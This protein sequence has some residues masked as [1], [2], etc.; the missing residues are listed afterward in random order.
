MD[1][2]EKFLNECGRE[3]AAQGKN[4]EI[5]ALSRQWICHPDLMRYSYHFSWLGRPIIQY[6][7]DMI[8]MQELLWEIKPDLVIETGI[9]HG[10]SLI[11]YASI[12]ELN[13]L[14]GGPQKAHVLGLD[15]DIR[16]HNREA[17]ENH[18]IYRLGR[19]SMIEGSS[20]DPQI[21]RRVQD[22]AAQY[23]KIMVVLDSN[24]THA[25]VL[26]ELEAYA[27]LVSPGSYCIVFDTIV[28]QMPEDAYPQ[29]PWGRG[30]NPASAVSEFLKKHPRFRVDT[31]ID[32]KLLISVAPGGYLRAD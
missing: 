13:A 25:H 26:A 19:I 5:K 21:I 24:H 1:E 11:F 31:S 16:K 30:D 20:V 18:P 8:A 3:I 32:D 29:R 10:G 14:C 15:I 9:A 7:Q 22:M 23:S 27:P 28:E 12:L 2:H 6:P 4:G 17:I